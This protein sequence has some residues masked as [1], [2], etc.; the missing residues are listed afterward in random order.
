MYTYYCPYR[1]SYVQIR[2]AD[3]YTY[4]KVLKNKIDFICIYI[5][6]C[7]CIIKKKV[8]WHVN[9]TDTP[10]LLQLILSPYMYLRQPS[11][12]FTY[13]TV[14]INTSLQHQNSQRISCKQKILC[15]YT[16]FNPRYDIFNAYLVIKNNFHKS[17]LTTRNKSFLTKH[18]RKMVIYDI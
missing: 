8:S 17:W 4:L 18:F 1:V 3:L 7:K 10:V 14:T 6:I 9:D 15:V 13:I 2:I 11:L 12:H 5:S 16:W